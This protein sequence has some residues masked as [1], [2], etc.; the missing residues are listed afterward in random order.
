MLKILSLS[1][2]FITLSGCVMTSNQFVGPNGNKAYSIKCNGGIN[3]M[4]DC[5]EELSRLCPNG[6]TVIGSNERTSFNP[7]NFQS[8][9]HRSLTGECK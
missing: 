5:Y 9:V 3:S 8:G 2:I 4:G 6:Y 7:V 1:T